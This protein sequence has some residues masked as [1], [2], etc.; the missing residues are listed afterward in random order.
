MDQTTVYLNSQD[1]ELFKEFL[2]HHD[3]YTLIISR[4]LDTRAG[5]VNVMIDEHGVVRKVETRQT[6]LIV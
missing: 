5:S 1:A 4:V 2:K 6:F 3:L